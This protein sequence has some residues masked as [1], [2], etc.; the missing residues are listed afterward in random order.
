[1][2]IPPVSE[3]EING[4]R[5]TKLGSRVYNDTIV[6]ETDPRGKDYFWI[7][8]GKPGWN[9]DNDSDF[10]A[11]SKNYVSITPIS[12]E[13]TDY[14]RIFDLKKWDLQWKKD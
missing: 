12:I 4:I 13:M 10:S 14:K 3:D 6:K 8:G 11:V 7:G 5:I 1:M 2:N 9:E